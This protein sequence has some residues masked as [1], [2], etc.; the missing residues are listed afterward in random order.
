M[1]ILQVN[2]LAFLVMASGCSSEFFSATIQ[3]G[4][5]SLNRKNLHLAMLE[6]REALDYEAYVELYN[7][8]WPI[9]GEECVFKR[10]TAGKYRLN[11]IKNHQRI[12]VSSDPL[13]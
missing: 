2:T 13:E 4:Y 1:G 7:Y 9:K 12:Y 10:Q 6:N 8:R 3:E 5:R 11:A